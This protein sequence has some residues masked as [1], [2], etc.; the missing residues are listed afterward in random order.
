[1][2]SEKRSIGPY[3]GV[4]SEDALGDPNNAHGQMLAW[5][6]PGL[7]VLEIGCATGYMSRVLAGHYRCRVTGF[8]RN[9]AAAQLAL[10]YLVDLVVGDLERQQDRDK[11][12]RQFDIVIVGDVLEHLAE[13]E[14]VLTWLVSRL[15]VHGKM[16]V[17]LPNVAHWSIRRNLLRGRWDVTETGLMDGTH[18]RWYTRGSAEAMLLAAGLRIIEHKSIYLFP[19]RWQARLAPPIARWA[20]RHSIPAPIDN[21]IA[22][23]HLFLAEPVR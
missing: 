11:V 4:L 22:C 2:T 13:P 12:D 3:D 18:L 16:I 7:D 9:K 20:R 14:P 10:P 5:V 15:V 23:Q 1:M 8:E 21:V 6:Q 19:A 17:S